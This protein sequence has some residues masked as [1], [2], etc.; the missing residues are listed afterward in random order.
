MK[1]CS[2]DPRGPQV[3]EMFI[4]AHACPTHDAPVIRPHLSDTDQRRQLIFMTWRI[5]APLRHVLHSHTLRA[6]MSICTYV[7]KKKYECV[8]VPI[9]VPAFPM[10]LLFISDASMQMTKRNLTSL[11]SILMPIAEN[12]SRYQ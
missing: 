4:C 3:N 6:R 7:R 11:E 8:Y 1:I 12:E 2:I 9:Q 5:V 10:L